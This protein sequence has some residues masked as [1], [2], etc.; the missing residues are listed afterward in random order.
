MIIPKSLFEEK[1]LF[2]KT[3][4]KDNLFQIRFKSEVNTFDKNNDNVYFLL[5][6]TKKR[7]KACILVH[8]LGMEIGSKWDTYLRVVPETIGACYID[9]PY[10][11]RRKTEKN[12]LSS[13]SDGLFTLNFFRQG[14]LDIIKTVSILKNLGY[15]E[16]SIIGISLGSMFSIMSMALDKRIEKGVFILSGGDYSIITWKSPVMYKVR[17][18]YRKKNITR[19]GCLKARTLLHTFTESVKKCENPFNVKSNIIC[20]YFDPLSFAPLIEPEKVL[21]IN[22]LFDF[23]IPR[24]ATLRLHTALGKPKI[25]WFPTDHLYL[26][27]FKNRIITYIK[28]FLR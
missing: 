7:S 5:K 4:L 1:P 27:I 22:G 3:R 18:A 8:G 26:Y 17:E 11:R 23:I 15:K 10:Q 16:I 12:L 14:T 20:L 24:Q 28:S 6:D 9:L 25:I 21:M 13:F 2:N 19:R